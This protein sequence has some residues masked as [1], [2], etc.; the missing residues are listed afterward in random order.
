MNLCVSVLLVFTI[1]IS[2]ETS[3][4]YINQIMFL[5]IVHKHGGD[6]IL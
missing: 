3:F 2:L 1:V 4:A 6:V 5:I